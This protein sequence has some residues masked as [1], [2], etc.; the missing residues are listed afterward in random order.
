M[1]SSC[2][3]PLDIKALTNVQWVRVYRTE[4]HL[5][6]IPN[7]WQENPCLIY[8]YDISVKLKAECSRYVH[9]GR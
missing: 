7:N 9:L 3:R 2:G 1:I 6:V 4:N 8:C 5:L